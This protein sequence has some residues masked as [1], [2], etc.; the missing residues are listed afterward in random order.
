MW[1]IILGDLKKTSEDRNHSPQ[2]QDLRVDRKYWRAG[3]LRRRGSSIQY[4]VSWWSLGHCVASPNRMAPHYASMLRIFHNSEGF[5]LFCLPVSGVL[6]FPFGGSVLWSTSISVL[7]T[8]DTG[9]T[10]VIVR[11]FYLRTAHVVGRQA[12]GTA[13]RVWIELLRMRW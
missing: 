4:T 9:W 12:A 1:A 8:C 13:G 5:G 2:L 10:N 6:G 11:G 3:M 7:W